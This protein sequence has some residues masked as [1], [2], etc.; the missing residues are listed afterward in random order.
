MSPA[1]LFFL[2]RRHRLVLLV[3]IVTGL[4]AGWITAPGGTDAP[5]QYEAT[6]TLI[7]GAEG[8]GVNLAQLA[9]LATTGAVPDRA[10]TELG[11][12]RAA[13]QRAVTARE[14][15]EA[16]SL[17]ITAT[18]PDAAFAQDAA[19]AVAAALIAQQSDAKRQVYDSQVADLNDRATQLRARIAAGGGSAAAQAE[20]DAAQNELAATL[21]RL[22][23]ITAAGPPDAALVTVQAAKAGPASADGIQAPS[24]K[25]ARAA[26]LGGF[27]LLLGLATVFALDRLDTRI[28]TKGSAEAAFGFPVIAE[29][30]PLP[31]GSHR[32]LLSETHP[33]S[34]FVEAYRGLR[35]FVALAG[36]ESGLRAPDF[37]DGSVI[38]VT[39]PLA[40][41]GKTTSVAHVGAMLG[42][43]GRSVLVVSGDFR[44]PRLHEMF[45]R[46]RSPGLSEVLGGADDAPDIADLELRTR[47]NNVQFMPSGAPVSNPA[48]IV[49]RTPA[50]L[51]AARKHWEFI[52]LDSA[53]LLVANDSSELARAANGVVVLARSGRTTVDAA[54]RTAEL[55]RRIEAPVLGVVLIAANESPTAYRYY[56][57]GY[58][59]E[60]EE[61]G[62][63]HWWHR[64]PRA[65]RGSRSGQPSAG[66]NPPPRMP[67]RPAH[68]DAPWRPSDRPVERPAGD[69]RS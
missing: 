59:A 21:Q 27:G 25:P 42:E 30:P 67:P 47:V 50:M 60:S 24:S 7:V 12:D 6:H 37:G 46:T 22:G 51:Q 62:G 16:N 64:H 38:L 68:G 8:N 56:R 66:S 26:L 28:H 45:Q 36:P 48:V 69:R 29:I 35:S 10:A 39:S 5:Q 11:V 63:G 19:N 49:K 58:Y 32:Q 14:D 13:I 40:G 3:A 23:A 57:K 17:K 52:I 4:A 41:E 33:A 65:R 44:R 34:Q 2:L 31:A 20:V 43:V 9:L 18:S 1:D 54:E 61:P 53:P 15:L 55:L